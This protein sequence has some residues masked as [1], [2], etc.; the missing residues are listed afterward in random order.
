MLR[1]LAKKAGKR[2]RWSLSDTIGTSVV[3]LLAGTLVAVY[4]RSYWVQWEG[5]KE[6]VVEVSAVLRGHGADNERRAFFV[7]RV[8]LPDGTEKEAQLSQVYAPGTR[9]KLVYSASPNSPTLRIH[10]AV[11]CP[12]ECFMEFQKAQGEQR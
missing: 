4:L 11:A 9:L 7:Y 6:A 3:V 2:R 12:E 10:S 1:E 5:P 8:S